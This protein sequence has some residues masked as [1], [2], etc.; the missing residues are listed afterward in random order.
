MKV[1][2]GSREIV[3]KVLKVLLAGLTA[4]AFIKAI[5]VSLDIDESYAVALGYRWEEATG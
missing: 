3:L 2:G 4:L 1:K 5:W